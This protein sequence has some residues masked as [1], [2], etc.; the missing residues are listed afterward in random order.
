[1]LFQVHRCL[2]L[3]TTFETKFGARSPNKK[4]NLGG[5]GTTRGKNWDRILGKR[6]TTP[7]FGSYLKFKAQ[8]LGYMSP[9]FLEAKFEALAR[10]FEAK[11]WAKPPPTS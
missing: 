5:C 11:F 7:I 1:M 10:I 8:N 3:A 6:S 4:K 9:M 2:D